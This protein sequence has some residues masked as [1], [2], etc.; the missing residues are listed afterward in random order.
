M[1]ARVDVTSAEIAIIG[2]G[3]AGLALSYHLTAGGRS[4]VI[5]EQGRTAESWRSKRWDALRLI[6]PNWSLVMPGFAYRGDDPDGFMSKDDVVDHLIRYA[7]SFGA[8]IREGVRVVSIERD[9]TDSTFVV[10]TDDGELRAG[11]VVI[12][13]GALQR[14]KVPDF[15]TAIP[16]DITQLIPSEYRNPGA[17][18]P[19]KVLIVG[20]G[21]TGC[22][23][24]EDLARANREVFLSGGRGWWTPRRY[25]GRDIT[26]WMR[27]VGWFERLAA[28]LPPGV[29]TGK[30]NPQLTGVDGGHD[31][32]PHSLSRAGVTL[33][34]RLR[35]VSDGRASFADDLAANVAWGDEQALGFLG[36]IDRLVDA[37]DLGVPAPDVPEDLIDA[38]RAQAGRQPVGE[39]ARTEIDLANDGISSVIWATGYRPDLGWVQLPF[40]DADGYPLHRRGITGVPGLYIVGLDWLHTAKS[41]LFAGIGDDAGYI[42]GAITATR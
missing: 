23:I 26:A 29:R 14:P 32:S 21:E 3:Q 24:A 33:L 27:L 20:T 39:S 10:R 11:T 35:G 9:R 22:Q 41:G 28:D 17:L 12:A 5:L 13:T 36:T 8:P 25:R 31:L 40:C 19:G 18:P 42:A 34:G 6:A 37:Q 2:G 30:S 1:V 7:T 4:H 15:A 16:H 38:G